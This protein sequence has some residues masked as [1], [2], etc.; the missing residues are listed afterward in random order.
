MKLKISQLA[1]KVILSDGSH[2]DWGAR[3]I[4]RIIQSNIENYISFKYLNNDL[5]LYYLYRM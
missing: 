5:K 1:K 2:R 3:P 4:R